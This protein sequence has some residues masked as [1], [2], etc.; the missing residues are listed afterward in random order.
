MAVPSLFAL[1]FFTKIAESTT[2]G[3]APSRFG[4]GGVIATVVPL[5]MEEL[6][7]LVGGS[8]TLQAYAAAVVCIHGPGPDLLVN[9]WSVGVC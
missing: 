5:L 2:N 6:L 8:W 9:A 1:F 7:G 4:A 3:G